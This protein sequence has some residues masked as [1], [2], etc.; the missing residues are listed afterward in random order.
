MLQHHPLTHTC[1]LQSHLRADGSHTHS[2]DAH[3]KPVGVNRTQLIPHSHLNTHHGRHIAIFTLTAGIYQH[4]SPHHANALFSYLL[5]S[6]PISTPDINAPSSTAPDD[7]DLYIPYIDKL[8]IRRRRRRLPSDPRVRRN[9]TA[10]TTDSS[11]R[12]S[13]TKFTYSHNNTQS[14]THTHSITD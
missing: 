8:G 13:Y 3:Y 10:P 1:F 6:E 9:G 11:K 14:H 7:D 2:V 12:E 5:F 4:C